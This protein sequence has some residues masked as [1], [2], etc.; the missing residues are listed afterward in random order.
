MKD[1][2]LI[3]PVEHQYL[4]NMV[5]YPKMQK[6]SSASVGDKFTY[7]ISYF[8]QQGITDFLVIGKDLWEYIPQVKAKFGINVIA[9]GEIRSIRSGNEALNKGADSIIV[10][11]HFYK[12]KASV[13]KFVKY[14][15]DKIICSINDRSGFIEATKIPTFEF[16]GMAVE[17]GIKKFLYVDENLKLVKK[18]LNFKN[19]SRISR[20][21]KGEYFYAGGVSRKTDL[22]KLTAMSFKKIVVGTSLYDGGLKNNCIN[23]AKGGGLIP[24]IIQEEKNGKVFMLGYMNKVALSKTIDTGYVHFWSRDRKK[25]WMKGEES[26]NKLKLEK[27]FL[28]CDNDALL[29]KVKLEGKF[30]CHTGKY[31]CFFD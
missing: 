12:N 6:L 20:C 21:F 11:R 15:G 27:I 2:K 10:A 24:A 19:I 13:G 26:G 22:K 25:I 23:Y 29:V 18:S 14:F 31:S 9:G 30:V 1:Y 5:H 3:L 8:F 4:D 7:V 17:S 16:I 28:D